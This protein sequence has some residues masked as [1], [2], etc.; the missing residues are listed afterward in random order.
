M[1]SVIIV[2]ND[3]YLLLHYILI[4]STVIYRYLQHSD[5]SLL[6]QNIFAIIE[7]G[8]VSKWMLANRRHWWA[9]MFIFFF[10]GI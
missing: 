7:E 9:N 3:I 6:I 2:S 10:T 4:S 8:F 5:T 1:P